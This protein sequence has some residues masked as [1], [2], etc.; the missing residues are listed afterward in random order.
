MQAQTQIRIQ[1]LQNELNGLINQ[2]DSLKNQLPI[3]KA[4]IESLE[5]Y[6]TQ[7]S[8][9]RQVNTAY[10][11]ECREYN[12]VCNLIRKNEIRIL[13]IE[14]NLQKAGMKAQREAIQEQRACIREQ[15]AYM[16]QQNAYMKQMYRGY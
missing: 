13:K 10:R 6:L 15:R 2:N 14:E 9:N 1:T 8:T 3:R 7:D 12:Q 5:G 4:K 11:K 16:R